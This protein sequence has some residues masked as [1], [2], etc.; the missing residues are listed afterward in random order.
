M[1]KIEKGPVGGL[2]LD[3]LKYHTVGLYRHIIERHATVRPAEEL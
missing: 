3:H 1:K 2:L